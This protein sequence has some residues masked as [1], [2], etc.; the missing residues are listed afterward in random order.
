[1]RYLLAFWVWSTGSTRA[2]HWAPGTATFYAVPRDIVSGSCQW[3]K[4]W[5]IRLVKKQT[6]KPKI[7]E[8]TRFEGSKSPKQMKEKRCQKRFFF[9]HT[10]QGNG[11]QLLH[12]TALWVKTSNIDVLIVLPLFVFRSLSS[13]KHQPVEEIESVLFILHT[14]DAAEC[15][16]YS[17]ALINW[18]IPQPFL[19]LF[20]TSAL[21]YSPKDTCLSLVSTLCCEI[22]VLTNKNPPSLLTMVFWRQYQPFIILLISWH[23]KLLNSTLSTVVSYIGRCL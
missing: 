14:Q 13:S 22:C 7:S 2:C 10:F 9:N 11:I 5:F 15:H 12:K 1:M 16:I 6:I 4:T 23:Y 8:S 17:W 19:A 20:S 18:L 21:K 3:K